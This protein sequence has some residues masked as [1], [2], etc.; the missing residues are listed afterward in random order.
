ME[1]FG[2][3]RTYVG[4]RHALIAR[5]GHVASVFPGWKGAIAYVLISPAMGAG[6]TQLMAVFEEDGAQIVF[7]MDGYEHVIYVESGKLNWGER[8]FDNGDFFF[9]PPATKLVLKGEKGTRLTIFRKQYEASA[10]VKKPE[11]V[12]GSKKDVV[13]EPFLG[14][15]KTRLQVLLPTDDRYDLAVNIFTYESGATLPF[16]ET[17]VMEH[18]LKM[19][20]GQGVYRLED[21][22]YPVKAGDVI[23]MAAYCSQWFVAMGDEPASYIYSKNINRLP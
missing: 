1:L 14:N 4:A 15:E 3:T 17:H 5:D 10:R 22:Y 21:K 11:I 2:A 12:T 7:P 8:V 6:I 18:G 13:G 16:V 20:A 19:L 23:W 9:V